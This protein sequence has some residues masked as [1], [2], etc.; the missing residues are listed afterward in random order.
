MTFLLGVGV[1][2]VIGIL[3]APA[4]HLWMARREWMAA[5]REAELAERLLDRV[6]GD[7]D[8]EPAPRLPSEPGWR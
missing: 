8:G 4:F 3:L 6:M 2:L 7:P 5:S 1:G